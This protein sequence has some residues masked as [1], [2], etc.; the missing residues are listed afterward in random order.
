VGWRGPIYVIVWYF[1]SGLFLR[2]ISPPFGKLT[3]IEQKLEGEYRSCH[4]DLQHHS[5]EIAFY[6]GHE[7]ERT[8]ID[9]SFKQL[10]QH[11]K[12][13]MHKRLYMGCF[14]AMLVK[15]GAVLVGYAILGLPVFGPGRHE[16]LKKIGNDP[17]AITRD[18]VRNSSLLINLAKAI[19]RLVVSYKEIQHL[20]GYTALVYEI[21]DV[22][23]D[24]EE[25]KYERIMI[26]DGKQAGSVIADKKESIISLSKG[27][28]IESETIRFEEVPIVSPNGDTL[29]EKISFEIKPGMNC[30][31][32]GPNGCGKS[33]LFRIL[34][35]LW[36][37][38]GGKLYRPILEKMFYIPQRPYLPPGTLRDQIIY[39]HSLEQ[40]KSKGS[41]DEDIA[42]LLEV[43]H[44]GYLIEREGSLDSKND[45]NDVLSGGEKQRVAMARLFYHKPQFAILDECTSAVSMDVEAIMYNYSKQIGITLFTVSHRQSLFKFHDYL[46]RF[47]GEGGWSFEKLIHENK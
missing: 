23:C 33:S 5:E 6:R 27:E 2:F 18:Y 7:W 1:F 24:L 46:L 39:P 26:A 13:V 29:V 37:L 32:T 22:L 9:A 8:R 28:I 14:D 25:G 40:M 3:A 10:M 12:M 44:L 16:Y 20:A 21:K 4:T 31:V 42:K 41:R 34:G 38:F 30:I 47:D 35:S 45:W 43:V 17:S 11:S 15:Y 36:P 19:G